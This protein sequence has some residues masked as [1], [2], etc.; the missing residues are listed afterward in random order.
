LVGLAIGCIGAPGITLA[1]EGDCASLMAVTVG[2]STIISAESV[3]TPVVVSG[4]AVD[5]PFCRV[6][7]VARPS[8]D[9]E[10]K[11]EVWLPPAA[12]WSGRLKV[13]GTGGFAG[14]TP[15]ARL[16]QDIADGF[17][18]AGSNMG[19][20]GGEDAAWTRGHPE[21]VKD[22]GQRAHHSVATA[23]KALSLAFYARPVR[24][25]YFE[26]CSNGGRQALMLAQNYPDLFDGIVAGAPSNFYPDLLM[27]LLW[28]GKQQVPV[29]GQPPVLSAEKRAMITRRVLAA[30]DG[31]D[32]LVDGQI[33]N[34]R[35]CRFDVHSLGSGG[36]N[37]LTEAELKVVR[38][39]YAG[40]T[41]ERGTQRHPG[42]KLGSESD[43][44]P[45]FADRGAYGR[46]IGHFVHDVAS[47]PFEWRRDID[48]SA[49][50]DRVKAALTP[51]TAAPSPDLSA[52]KRRGGKLIQYHGWNDAVVPPDGSI[53]YLHAL[54]LFEKLRGLPEADI[55]RQVDKLSPQEVAATAEAF[56]QQVQQYHRLFMMPG[57]GH[58]GGGTGP[59][60]IG[61]GAPEPPPALR[62]AEHHVVRAVMRWVEQGVPP[63]QIV[64]SRI[65]ANGVI[66]RQRPLCPYPAQAAYKGSGDIDVASNFACVS[67]TL[68]E[69]AISA[70]D[71]LQIQ[72]ALRQ[73]A[74][75]LPNR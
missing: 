32:G 44:D 14:A 26:G 74:L 21:K 9:S 40:T 54:A 37:S 62:D 23:A 63:E 17:V 61:G 29:L 65:G 28:A 25:A 55:D 36:D 52:F 42:A 59:G 49:V 57:A 48:F 69:R 35:A 2:A 50:Y 66:Q 18:T 15:Y 19:H 67:P 38:A 31:D 71:I 3:T 12:A 39:M 34:P 7:G 16:A 60:A 70:G 20:D 4:A 41:S 53:H 46:F 10:I 1:G 45:D 51:I 68:Q 56:G 8:P 6:K 30:C 64:A 11:Y 24:Y 33:T 5:V 27:W 43:W 13:N 73:R 22:W 47:P 72:S 58:C 75:L